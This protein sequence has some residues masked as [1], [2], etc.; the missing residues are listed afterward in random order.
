MKCEKQTVLLLSPLSLAYAHTGNFISHPSL[1]LPHM[2]KNSPPQTQKKHIQMN[3]LISH[4][5]TQMLHSLTFLAPTLL[6]KHTRAHEPGS[7]L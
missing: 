3:M 6:C 2:Y 5:N 7:S 1:N 4:T